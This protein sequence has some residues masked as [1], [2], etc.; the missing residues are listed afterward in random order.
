MLN[1]NASIF[2]LNDN[3]Y[4]IV[5]IAVIFHFQKNSKGLFGVPHSV[6]EK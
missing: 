1:N 6:P 5:G 2:G 4:I 3:Y